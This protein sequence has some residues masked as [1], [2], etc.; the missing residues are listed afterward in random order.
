MTALLKI[1][2]QCSI[3]WSDLSR[4]VSLVATIVGI[5]TIV[6]AAVILYAP[7]LRDFF[8]LDDFIWLRAAQTPD[9][10]QFFRDATGFP[11][12]TAYSV[13]TPFWRPLIDAY[14]FV[15]WRLFGMNPAPY[16]IVNVA[17]HTAN[18]VLLAVLVRQLTRSQGAAFL[19][20]LLWVIL[21]VY[22]YAVVWISEATELLATFWYLLSLV[23]FVAFLRSPGRPWSLYTGALLSMSLA[24]LA[25]QSSVTIPAVLAM[26]AVL[27]NA[28]RRWADARRM[29]VLLLPFAVVAV[30]YA[31]FLY[32]HDYRTSAATGIYQAGPHALT[33]AWDYLLRLTWP[34]VTPGY[35]T[36]SAAS[37]VAVALVLAAGCVALALRL[38]LLSFAFLW[39][40]IALL[41]YSF[42]PAGTES[43][44]LYL[45]AIPFSLFLVLL[46][47]QI[48]SLVRPAPW[49]VVLVG[50]IV[51]AL[52]P[53]C[54]A[55][56]RE[57][58]ERQAWIHQ[59][60]RA[61]HQVFLEVPNLCGVL[62]DGGRITVVGGPM[63]DLFGESTRMALNLRYP[64]VR[65]ER[66]D[67]SEDVVQPVSCLVRYQE[68]GYERVLP[69]RRVIRDR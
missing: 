22:D 43:R 34:F 42:F 5:T 36:D 2:R 51:L 53:L 16:H 32:Q 45:A 35:H 7:F 21:P 68:D 65:V 6:A 48:L 10:A 64:R 8:V 38:P 3:L 9:T 13:P 56:G 18:A 4:C 58:R 29:A 24:L 20:A 61:Y 63:L 11:S 28:P 66:L 59:Q 50:A 23:L 54:M 60:S 46:A 26:L 57:T 40:M 47:C 15:A 12:A 37:A 67:D 30:V 52:P 1:R 62:P 27:I 39:M 33:N 17:V 41:P 19:T 25:K 55:L 49:R 31:L 44:Y 69:E 14:F